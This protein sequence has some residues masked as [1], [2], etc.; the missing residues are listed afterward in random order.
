VGDTSVTCSTALFVPS[1]HC[2]AAFRLLDGWLGRCTKQKLS[3]YITPSLFGT[4]KPTLNL[5]LSF[6]FYY[7]SNFFC[8]HNRQTHTHTHTHTNGVIALVLEA[9]MWNMPPAK[10]PSWGLGSTH[11]IYERDYGPG[12]PKT[13][14]WAGKFCMF[15]HAD[16]SCSFDEHV[17]TRKQKVR[18]R[19]FSCQRFSEV[20][21]PIFKPKVSLQ[22]LD[23][24][25]NV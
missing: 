15:T 3:L 25:M 8:A 18:H 24:H 1:W 20:F 9:G 16:V 5:V 6:R 21:M 12:R 11:W 10:E 22:T 13:S 19:R 7:P 14:V 2:A 4:C 17:S 23:T